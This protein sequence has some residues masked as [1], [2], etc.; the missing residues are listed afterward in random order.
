MPLKDGAPGGQA[1]ARRRRPRAIG[2]AGRPTRREEAGREDE[3]KDSE[4]DA[5]PGHRRST[6]RS[7][8]SGAPERE[9]VQ[10]ILML[11]R[12]ASGGVLTSC[13]GRREGPLPEN[14]GGEVLR[15]HAVHR[16]RR[17]PRDRPRQ[18]PAQRGQGLSPTSSSSPANAE[19]EA[20]CQ[21]AMD[22]CPVEA[23]GDRRTAL[24]GPGRHEARGSTRSSASAPLRA[25][26]SAPSRASRGAFGCPAGGPWGRPRA[27][28]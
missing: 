12:R 13:R 1:L 16:L 14:A 11:L 25:S 10:Q 20:Q 6:A 24:G 3:K 26:P 18:L 22:S 9:H 23:I 19:E 4:S 8:T 17:L 15:G 21:E 2:A 27:G 28:A 5:E 7:L